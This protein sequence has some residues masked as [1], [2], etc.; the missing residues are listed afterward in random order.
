M[1]IAAVRAGNNRKADTKPESQYVPWPSCPPMA[2]ENILPK[3]T[4]VRDASAFTRN[5]IHGLQ[6]AERS[7]APNFTTSPAS[8]K[9]VL[10]S[11][12]IC[13]NI[14]FFEDDFRSLENGIELTI[15]TGTAPAGKGLGTVSVLARKSD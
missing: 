9:V 13:N 1:S 3:L 5:R 8:R 14:L 4:S 12:T 7:L 11:R 10:S 2:D 6:S 15:T